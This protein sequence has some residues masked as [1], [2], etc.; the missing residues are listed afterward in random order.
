MQY[1]S[2]LLYVMLFQH[3]DIRYNITYLP[4][5]ILRYVH[6]TYILTIMHAVL[7]IIFAC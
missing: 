2:D 6:G 1:S 4:L 3:P 7:F 5:V